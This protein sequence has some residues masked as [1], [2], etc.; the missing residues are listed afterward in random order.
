VSKRYYITGGNGQLGR[1]LAKQYPNATV[2]DKDVLDISNATLVDKVN[3][4]NY[5][6]II[7]AAAYVNADHSET[8]RG[9]EI[10]WEANAVGPRN[11]V[12]VA[13]KYNLHL[14]HISSEYVF[15]GTKANHKEDEPFTPLS[16]YGETKA[17][18]DIVV[19]LV[20]RHHILRTSWVVGDGHNFVKTMKNLAEIRVDPKV[21]DDQFGRLTFTSELV[22]AIDHILKNNVESGTYN[23]SNC[24]KIRSWLDIAARTFELA[25]YDKSR[26][27][28][29]STDEYKRDKQPFAPRPTH[30]DLDLS[31]IQ[32]TGFKSR[33]YDPL[34]KEYVEGLRR[35]G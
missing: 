27:K 24:G 33:D 19:S 28:P 15:D 3:W 11:L 10:T 20:P 31:K 29:I 1:A 22:R 32:K 12:K 2:V 5:D 34:M 16:V 4:S 18:G 26:V 35:A 9:R 30:S 8:Q 25:G 6:V 21:V 17:A 13:L 7:N 14:I 23:L